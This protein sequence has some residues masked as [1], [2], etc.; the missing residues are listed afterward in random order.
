MPQTQYNGV[1]TIANSDAYNLA[2]DL[3]TL[4]QTIN[5]IVPVS[6]DSQRNALAPP[7]GLFAGM[8]VARTDKPG[9]PLEVRDSGGTWNVNVPIEVLCNNARVGTS[10]PL[11]LLQSGMIRPIIQAGTVVVTTDVNGYSNFAFPVPFPNGVFCWVGMNGDD[12]ATG[13]TV[14][15]T[16]GTAGTSLTTAYFNAWKSSG[17]AWASNSFRLDWVA[18][19]W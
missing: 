1:K 2:N 19:G 9:V 3:A 8:T 5:A 15:V 18:I 14:F 17:S 7:Q 6:S 16:Q 12:L 13:D 10:N 11:S 4:G